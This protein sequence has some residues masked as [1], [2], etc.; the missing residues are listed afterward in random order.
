[1]VVDGVDDRHDEADVD[2]RGVAVLD[3]AQLDVEEVADL[4]VSVRRFAHAVELQVRDP[5][6]RLARRFRERG[7]LRQADP[8]GRRLHAEVTDLGRVAHGVEEDRRNGGLAAGEL[9]GHLPPRLDRQRIVQKPLHLVE[10]QLVDVADLIRVHEAGV[11]HHVAAVGQVDRQDRPA[12]V[13]DRRG[14]VIVQRVGDRIE[15]AAGEET[16]DPAQKIRIDG[17]RV[18]ERSVLRAGLLDDHLAVALDDVRFDL[19]DVL[20]DEGG[21]GLLAREDS[22]PGLAHAGGTERVGRPRPA[23]L[24]LRTL[25]ALHER[26]RRPLGLEGWRLELPV[27]GLEHRPGRAGRRRLAAISRGLHTF[28]RSI[29]QARA[30]TACR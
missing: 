19:A 21:N 10:R 6:A 20:V 4:A 25:R 8:V 2:P 7:V 28:I 3:R 24:R 27:D 23:Q 11:A 29:S 14:A 16:L 30:R 22:R 5:Q 15:V 18:G 26:R 12:P 1:M 9:H 13:L 17:Q